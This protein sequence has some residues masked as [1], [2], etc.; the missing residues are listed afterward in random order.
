[1]RPAQAR[2]IVK[3]KCIESLIQA[4]DPKSCPED[5]EYLKPLHAAL[6]QLLKDLKVRASK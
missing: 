5:A 2:L 3:D 6:K 4:C 1:M